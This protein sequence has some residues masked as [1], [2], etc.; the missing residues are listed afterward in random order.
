MKRIL[1]LIV[2]GLVIA[3]SL[4]LVVSQYPGSV[5]I[6]LGDWLV[7]SNLW[8]M[9]GLNIVVLW[10]M[11]LFLRLFQGLRYS[12]GL[13]RRMLGPLGGSRAQQNTEKGLIALLEGNWRHANRL[14]SRSAAKSDTPLINYLAAAHAAHE[15]GDLKE[16]EQHLKKAYENT[17]DSEF[18][19]GIVQ[20]QIQLQQNQFE[21]CLAT[22]L[23]LKKQQVNH[24]FV[25]KLLKSVYLRLEDWQQLL[26][27]IPSLRKHTQAN[28]DELL[29]LEKLAWEN[30]FIQQ[31][32]ELIQQNN[33][34]QTVSA[35]I[36]AAMWKKIPDVLRFD[37]LLIEIYATQLMRLKSDYECEVLLRK[38]LSKQWDDKLVK[39]Y[40]LVRGKNISEQLKNAE[41][42]LKQKPNNPIL[43]LTLGRLSLRNELWGKALEYFEVSARLLPSNETYAELSRLSLKLNKNNQALLT[44]LIESLALP[45]LPLPK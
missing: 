12:K 5:R 17:S 35:E 23:R 27:L 2:F 11:S 38:V 1:S 34:T 8:V 14:L 24:P 9:L 7:E 21:Q 16:A 22:L 41:S 25:L 3:V 29:S 19:V 37:S 36:L 18:A 10:A 31:T 6:I 33:Q 39:L 30:L 32:D 20:A 44:G 45:D 26:H 4:S 40:G 42:W 28:D 13:F 15:L 43:L